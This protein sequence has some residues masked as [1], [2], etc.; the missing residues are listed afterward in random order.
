MKYLNFN[1]ELLSKIDFDINDNTNRYYNSRGCSVPR[2][3]DIISSIITDDRLMMWANSIG[4]KGLVY[5]KELERAA[6][7]GNQAHYSIEMYLKEKVKNETNI[8]FLGFLLWEETL[9][10]KGLE[11]N[12][13][14][15]EHK[16]SCEWFG[17]TCDAVMQI[18]NK[19]YLVDFK[20]SNHVTF[21]YFLQL[22][23]YLYLLSLEGIIVDGVI[24]LQLDKKYPGFNEYLLDFSV[25]EHF[26][27]MNNCIITFISLVNTY[28]NIKRVSN[29]YDIIFGG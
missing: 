1:T 16:M 2:V 13:I 28:F 20:T 10:E 7:I 26:N 11:I 9:N 25:P 6:T 18:G 12:P 5:R 29:E 4:R 24:V 19:K 21:K 23:A 22:A 3:T 14:L 15:I 17:G 27:F 8:P